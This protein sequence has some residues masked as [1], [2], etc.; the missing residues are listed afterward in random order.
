MKKSD[1]NPDT[2]RTRNIV[3]EIIEMLQKDGK[4]SLSEIRAAFGF[5]GYVSSIVADLVQKGEIVSDKLGNKV[6]LWDVDA[7]KINYRDKNRVKC[8]KC[9]QFFNS[10]NVRTNRICDNCKNTGDF[11]SPDEMH[12][13]KPKERKGP[14]G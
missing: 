3:R 14:T 12:V 8:L 5:N 4:C 13:T 9:R 7:W 10:H 6:F 2:Y 1:Y 11:S